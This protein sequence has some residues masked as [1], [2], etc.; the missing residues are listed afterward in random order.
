MLDHASSRA[1]HEAAYGVPQTGGIVPYV[2]SGGSAIQAYQGYGGGFFSSLKNFGK[3]ILGV[4]KKAASVIMPHIVNAG[5]KAAITALNSEGSIKDRLKSGLGSLKESGLA[6]MPKLQR[7][8]QAAI[9]SDGTLQ[10]RLET[11]PG[12]IQT[13]LAGQGMRRGRIHRPLI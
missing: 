9:G 12:L 6:A 1:V 10:Q 2:G 7:A 4:G 8:A 13:G 3:S 5:K 11:L